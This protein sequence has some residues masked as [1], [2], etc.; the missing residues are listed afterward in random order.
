MSD[1]YS[2]SH[3][4]IAEMPGLRWNLRGTDQGGAIDQKN[5][6]S[7]HHLCRRRG[8]GGEGKSC[9]LGVIIAPQ[10]SATG[11]VGV[12]GASDRSLLGVQDM[13]LPFF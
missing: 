3:A 11:L 12:T 8:V 9:G 6:T 13:T 5:N 7:V 2:S 1:T 10:Q 4:A